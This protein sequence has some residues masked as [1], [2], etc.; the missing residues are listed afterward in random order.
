MSRQKS[1]EE[2]AQKLFEDGYF[3]VDGVFPTLRTELEQTFQGFQEFVEHPKFDELN[4]KDVALR[5][6]CGGTSFLSSPSIFH[7]ITSQKFRARTAAYLMPVL[8]R[9]VAKLGN[10]DYKLARYLDR[11]QVRPKGVSA[12]AEHWHR[13][14]PPETHKGEFWTGG[15]QN[16]DPINMKFSCIKKSHKLDSESKGFE[17][18]AKGEIKKLNARLAAQAGQEDTDEDGNIVVPPGHVIVFISTIIHQVYSKPAVETSVKHFL[19]FR[20]TPYDTSGVYKTVKEA[21]EELPCAGKKKK[22]TKKMITKAI[23]IPFDELEKQM[24]DNAVMVLPSGQPPPMYPGL[25]LCNQENLQRR[26]LPFVRK[27][28]VNGEGSMRYRLFG[29]DGKMLRNA[30]GKLAH[31][32]G[33]FTDTRS[34]KSLKE[35]LGHAVYPYN[36]TEIDMVRPQK[37]VRI[38]NFDEKK[39]DIFSIDY[40][41]AVY[42]TENSMYRIADAYAPHL[43]PKKAK[44]SKS[45][46]TGKKGKQ[47]KKTISYRKTRSL[48]CRSND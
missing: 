40:D 23:E 31:Q 44:Q 11:I 8:A 25:Y 12:T 48:L 1:A 27:M 42:K 24:R 19:G 34:M 38:W 46:Q 15:F 29:P 22:R 14:A 9:F 6:I 45:K 2:L 43:E 37:D 35:I 4:D 41:D 32:G 21:G 13:D 33:Q 20:I 39:V 10:P 26:Y 30:D 36:K 17:A 7:N 16:C 28:L 5:Y 18:V 3:V 47:T